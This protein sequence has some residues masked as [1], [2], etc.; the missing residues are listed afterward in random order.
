[1]RVEQVF[2]VVARRRQPVEPRLVHI[3]VA[4]GARTGAPA[5][6]LDVEAPVADHLHDAPAI[7]P[8]ELVLFPRLVDDKNLHPARLRPLA[9]RPPVAWRLPVAACIRPRPAFSAAWS[10]SSCTGTPPARPVRRWPWPPAPSA[11]PRGSRRGS[12]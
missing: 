8:F 2:L 6:G 1:R 12:A 9:G 3:D 7:E 4:R 5:L 11:P 10:S